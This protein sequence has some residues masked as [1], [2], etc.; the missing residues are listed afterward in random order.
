MAQDLTDAFERVLSNRIKLPN[1]IAALRA[2]YSSAQP[3]PHLVLQDLFKSEILDPIPHEME[4]MR[5]SDWH[6]VERDSLENFERMRTA[7]DM[8]RAGWDLA[9]LLHSPAFLY[10]LSEITGIWQLIPDPYLQGAGY[11]SMQ[12]GSFFKVHSDR[13]TAYETGLTRRLALIVFLNKAWKS[14]YEGKLE[15]WSHDAKTCVKA[16]EPLFNRTVLFEVAD[17]NY[18]GV[19]APIAC[20][21]DRSR[22][23]FICYFHTVGKPDSVNVR[24]HGSAFAPAF[25]RSKAINFRSFLL[26]LAPPIL[27]KG[28]RTMIKLVKRHR[29]IKPFVEPSKH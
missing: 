10:L 1:S 28:L 19:P 6:L 21:L 17:P 8:G 16:I 25:Y 26:S 13:S 20:P 15:L 12:R 27:V 23:S 22:Q 11:A 29:S 3:F 18:H 14:E 4:N 5:G 2:A 7:V 9:H 24:P